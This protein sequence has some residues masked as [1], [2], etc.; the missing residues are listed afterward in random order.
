[1]FRSTTVCC[2]I[3]AAISAFGQTNPVTLPPTQAAGYSL[4]FFDNF[5]SIDLSPNGS[6]AHNWYQS[7]W[8][9]SVIPS[10]SLISTPNSVL[11]LNWQRGQG[12]WNTSITTFA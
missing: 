8:W 4:S 7:L 11:S 9:D 12:S 2:G 10:R 6:G 3:L 1:M 5:D